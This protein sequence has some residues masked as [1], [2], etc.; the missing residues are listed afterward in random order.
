MKLLRR[1]AQAAPLFLPLLAVVGTVVGG[2]WLFFSVAVFLLALCWRL[3]RIAA[4]SLLC[5]LVSGLHTQSIRERAEMFCEQLEL[6][7]V[8]ELHGTVERCLT[9]GCVLST[10]WNGVRV[11]VRG[12]MPFTPGDVVRVRAAWREAAPPPVRGVFHAADWMRGQGIA[13][14]ADYLEGEKL[15][16]PLSLRTVQHWGLQM[17]ERLARRLMP[18]GSESDTAR[19]VLC[20]LVLGDKSGAENETMEEFRNGGCLH[21]FA[22]SGLHVGLVSG[23]LWLLLR[24]LRV[25]PVVIRPLLLVSVGVYV[26]MT[27]CAVPAIRAYIMLAVLLAG[28]MLQRRVN[29]LNTWSFA[30][31]LILLT[32]PS[33]LYNAGFILSFGIYA[34]IC[35]SLCLCMQ[36]TPWFGPDAYIPVSLRTPWEIRWSNAEYVVRGAVIVSLSAWLVSVPVTLYFFHSANS[37]SFL[38]NIA[39][40]PLLPVVMFCGLLHLCVGGIPWIGVASGWAAQ[41]SA[42]LLLGIVTWFGELP[43]AYLPAQPPASEHSLLIQGT[44]FGGSFAMLGNHGLLIDC[45]NEVTAELTT[46][47]TLFHAGYTPAVLLVSAPQL[48]AGGGAAVL[49]RM[50]PELRVIQAHELPAEGLVFETQAGRFTLYPP[51]ADSVRNRAIMHSPVV[52]WETPHRKVLYIG[53]ATFPVYSALPPAARKADIAILGKNP[54]MPVPAAA[55]EA[56]Q[57]ILLPGV[58][59][60]GAHVL[61]LQPQGYILL[62]NND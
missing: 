22:V 37:S 10:G 39:I 36:E 40:T 26:L 34:T 50:W 35:L 8:V 17:R 47:P 59:G 7:E 56:R 28:Y 60:E 44:R 48:N 42:A 52:L 6:Q 20:A 29:L 23:I 12:N 5:A 11:L 30:A 1:H 18:A 25:R 54:H 2:Y 43:Y 55:L 21:A 41:K 45:G 53:H 31:L 57:L 49:Q 27:G 16:K 38:T 46:V 33:Q 13:A 9:R 14:S 3:W 19:Q 51:P 15:A 4:C 61:R 58:P 62:E 24:L 32:D